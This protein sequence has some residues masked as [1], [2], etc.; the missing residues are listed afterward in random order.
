MKTEAPTDAILQRL[1]DSIQQLQKDVHR[2]EVWAG[3]L[4]GYAQGIP[5]YKPASDEFLLS[6]SEQE[7]GKLEAQS[8]IDWPQ[9]RLAK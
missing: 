7:N 1:N 2:I 6:G 4:S 3:A 5:E 8:G 9:L